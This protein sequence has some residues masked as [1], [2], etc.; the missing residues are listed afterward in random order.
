[1]KKR[2]LGQL[3]LEI[4]DATAKKGGST[5]GIVTKIIKE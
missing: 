1:M 3:W 4:T 2:I 5:H